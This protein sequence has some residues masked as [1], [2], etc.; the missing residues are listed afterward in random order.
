MAERTRWQELVP[1]SSLVPSPKNP[2][3]H[4]EGIQ[5]SISRFGFI[6]P[7]VI[8]ERTGQLIS[9]HGRM[10][11]LQEAQGG[12]QG[13]PEGI[14]VQDGEWLVP[15][16]RGW[17]SKSDQEA[18]AA[19]VALNRYVELGGWD[20][21]ALADILQDLSAV[22]DGLEGIGYDQDEI[23]ELLQ[24]IPDFGAVDQDS[25]PRLDEAKRVICP[26]CGHEFSTR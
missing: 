10:E 12:G 11:A 21:Q 2:K 15:V 3:L 26:Q 8:D 20:D 4:S 9:G 7:V 23:A 16:N 17:A 6:E 18:S 25:Q 14:E 13:P 19:L 22:P 1:L 5:T 24:T